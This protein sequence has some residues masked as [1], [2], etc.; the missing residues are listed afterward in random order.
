MGCVVTWPYTTASSV[1]GWWLCLTGLCPAALRPSPLSP[2]SLPQLA[3]PVRGISAELLQGG[4]S[5]AVRM[6]QSP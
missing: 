4:N 3:S 2:S 1:G 5:D 6:P